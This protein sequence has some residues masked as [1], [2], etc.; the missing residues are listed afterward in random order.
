VDSS[1]VKKSYSDYLD[2][3]YW[4]IWAGI[5][6][7]WYIGGWSA[8]LWMY[9]VERKIP[10]NEAILKFSRLFW[11]QWVLV[12]LAPIAMIFTRHAYKMNQVYDST[13]TEGENFDIESNNDYKKPDTGYIVSTRTDTK[14]NAEKRKTN[15]NMED[16]QDSPADN[17]LPITVPKNQRNRQ[18][19]DSFEKSDDESTNKDAKT[20]SLFTEN[21][22]QGSFK[23]VNDLKASQLT[24]NQSGIRLLNS[25]LGD[26]QGLTTSIKN[27]LNSENNQRD[28]ESRTKDLRPTSSISST[29]SKN[30]SKGFEKSEYPDSTLDILV[31]QSPAKVR[32][33]YSIRSQVKGGVN[34]TKES[35]GKSLSAF[36]EAKNTRPII[37]ASQ[38]MDV[39]PKK[40]NEDF[41]I[42]RSN[43]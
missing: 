31:N 22:Q 27:N 36:K 38:E 16:S 26:S 17:N 43:N 29:I 21:S 3:Y 24:E 39:S 42:L 35:M 2:A 8:I 18:S 1:A 33:G 11:W 14:L 20:V 4:Y 23:K 19:C 13:Q 15:S 6:A 30:I 40:K 9:I 12:V 34:S 7:I 28:D 37:E 5:G 32:Q 41:K 25:E 10:A